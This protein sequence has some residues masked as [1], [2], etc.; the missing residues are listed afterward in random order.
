MGR[1]IAVSEAAHGAEARIQF[2]R[3]QRKAID[4]ELRH[5]LGSSLPRPQFHCLRCGYDWRGLYANRPPEHCSRCHTKNWDRK[6]TQ[7][8][9]NIPRPFKR[10]I[11]KSLPPTTLRTPTGLSVV[12]GLPP[13]PAPTLPPPMPLSTQF[14]RR[15]EEPQPEAMISAPKAQESTATEPDLTESVVET[16]GTLS[17]EESL[18]I[19]QSNQEGTSE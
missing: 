7:D 11:W 8:P 3:R 13:P 5:L 18:A 19:M 14:N 9:K 10:V 17:D 15:M 4:A 12:N 1:D 16:A 2:L 6:A